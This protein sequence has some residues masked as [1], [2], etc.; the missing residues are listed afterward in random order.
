MNKKIL[1]IWVTK[2]VRG[3]S[4]ENQWDVGCNFI[5][6]KTIKMFD[7]SFYKEF[8]WIYEVLY[9]PLHFL[10]LYNLF[11]N[12]TLWAQDRWILWENIRYCQY[13]F[14]NKNKMDKKGL[15]RSKTIL[16]TNVFDLGHEK[17]ESHIK[18]SLW[19]NLIYNSIFWKYVT[20]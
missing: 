5:K 18:T 8:M 9:Y 6:K 13:M 16:I 2:F 15:K 7:M 1:K 3:A 17:N 12:L 20:T 14:I 11:K 19:N 10:L 4:Q